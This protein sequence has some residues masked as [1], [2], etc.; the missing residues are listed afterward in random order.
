MISLPPLDLR[1]GEARV[2][3]DLSCKLFDLQ[4]CALSFA[5]EDYEYNS[6]GYQPLLNLLEER[7]EAPVIIT[8]GANQALYA[9]MA[10]LKKRNFKNLG[11]RV[12]YW[13]RIPDIAE[14][15]D[16]DHTSF[17]HH[18]L[19]GSAADKID[20]YLLVLPN[21]P[22]SF[23]PKLDVLRLYKASLKDRGIP[24]IHD[25]AYYT[26]SY[27][28]TDHPIE[29]IG[30]VQIYSASKMFGLSALR[31]GWMV[32]YNND[33][34]NE[35]LDYI[36]TYTSGV[37]IASQKMV[38]HI[39]KR[40]QEVPALEEQFYKLSQEELKR[41]K[42]LFQT[43]NKELVELP[44]DFDKGC[45]VFAWIKP[46]TKNLFENL[47]IAGLPGSIFGMPGYYRLNLAAGYELIKEAVSR[48]NGYDKR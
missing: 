9:A 16:L 3:R 28:P 13:N 10:L 41:N 47:N 4:N 35:L 44:D 12:P 30:D 14:N 23:I 46:K 25:A 26:R 29:P 15:V 24:L 22:D 19:S 7:Y 2:L 33:Y 45:G 1:L 21:N 17:S 31:V 8:N 43:V 27:L 48:I 32:V 18:T 34:F 39:F 37:S 6:L 5:P 36:E 11:F 38:H 42:H 20:S 40:G